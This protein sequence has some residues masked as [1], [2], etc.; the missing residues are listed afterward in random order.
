MV[1]LHFCGYAR[2]RA[3]RPGDGIGQATALSRDFQSATAVKID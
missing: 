3:R 2:G 1:T